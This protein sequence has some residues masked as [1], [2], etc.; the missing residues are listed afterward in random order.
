MLRRRASELLEK[1]REETFCFYE[2]LDNLFETEIPD[3][4]KF[5][6]EKHI[7]TCE[8]CK[9]KYEDYKKNFIKS[10]KSEDNLKGNFNLYKKVFEKKELSFEDKPKDFKEIRE[11]DIWLVNN[12][13][14]P[15]PDGVKEFYY[16]N[17]ERLLYVKKVGKEI[18]IGF[19]INK[20]YLMFTTDKDVIISEENSTLG[21]DFAVE[22]WNGVEVKKSS[23]IAYTGSVSRDMVIKINRYFN[24]VN[25]FGEKPDSVVPTGIPLAENDIRR[26]FMNLE[27]KATKFMEF[28]VMVE[29]LVAETVE[30]TESEFIGQTER[31]EEW[32]DG[33]LTKVKK[34]L[35][36]FSKLLKKIPEP[37]PNVVGIISEITLLNFISVPIRGSEANEKGVVDFELDDSLK[38]HIE[39]EVK[40]DIAEGSFYVVDKFTDEYIEG[41]E[42][43][44]YKLE[45]KILKMKDDS[46]DLGEI[47]TDENLKAKII[48]EKWQ[49]PFKIDRGYYLIVFTFGKDKDKNSIAIADFNA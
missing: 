49:I 42:A 16:S 26:E 33:F 9:L 32:G 23:L 13:P 17:K 15:V 30:E 38:V 14:Y 19:P 27:R 25:G 46:V 22:L 44:F 3:N 39:R 48:S 34:I 1:F 4:M 2:I 24:Y 45:G 47:F 29:E 41:V 43:K 18:V 11:G 8:R 5:Y 20:D 35:E 31:V 40:G 37:V 21:F 36:D 12:Y 28:E 10:I 7:E 6:L